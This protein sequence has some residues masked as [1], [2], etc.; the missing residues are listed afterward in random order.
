MERRFL[1][2][3][4]GQVQ[5]RQGSDKT[6]RID[7]Y[8]AVFYDGTSRTEYEFGSL[9]EDRKIVER[10][11]YGSFDRAIRE[12]DVRGLYNHDPSALLGRTKAGT[13]RL[14]VDRIGLIYDIDLPSTTT[15]K[16]VAESVRRGDLAGSS[17]A[18]RITDEVWRKENKV[19]I[20]EIRGVELFD[21]GPVTYPAYEATTAELH[22]AGAQDE[23][24]ARHN[25]FCHAEQVRERLAGYN[26]RADAIRAG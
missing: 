16:D 14:H 15:G 5:L 7:G 2:G 8:A 23:L 22:S 12:D 13:L 10:I 11:M 19:D 20:R 18:F 9:W 25:A 3:D 4:A 24:I 17:F 6:R 21:V 1:Q 26:Q